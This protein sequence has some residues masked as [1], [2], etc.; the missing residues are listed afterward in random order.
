MG[1]Q[2]AGMMSSDKKTETCN[3]SENV[4]VGMADLNGESDFQ[5]AIIETAEIF[6]C[7]PDKLNIFLFPRTKNGDKIIADA[8]MKARAAMKRICP[9]LKIGLTLS[10]YDI[11][12]IDGGEKKAAELWKQDFGHY[13]PV[14]GGDDFIGIQNYTRKHRWGTNIIPRDLLMW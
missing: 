10:L 5:T 11:Q 13:L 3:P 4:Q 8:H 7:T 9:E 12:A 6:G 1:I 14:I 2:I